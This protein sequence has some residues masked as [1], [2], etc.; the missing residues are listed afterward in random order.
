[1]VKLQI[2]KIDGKF[3][4]EAK[5]EGATMEVRLMERAYWRAARSIDRLIKKRPSRFDETLKR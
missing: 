2:F 5:A 4:R 1:L 3:I